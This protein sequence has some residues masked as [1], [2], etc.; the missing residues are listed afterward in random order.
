MPGVFDPADDALAAVQAQRAHRDSYLAAA[1]A[2][3]AQLAGANRA[4]YPFLAAGDTLALAKSGN[5]PDSSVTRTVAD[6][7]VKHKVKRGFGFRSIGDWISGSAALGKGIVRGGMT[8]LSAP[9]TEAA[10]VFRNITASAGTTAGGATGGAAI[11]A[12]LGTVVPGVGN[13]VGAGVGALAGGTIGAIGGFLARKKVKV[14]D[15][16]W[17]PQSEALLAA[18]HILQGQKVDLGTGYFP[19]GELAEEHAVRSRNVTVDGHGLTPGRLIAASVAEPGSQ[20]HRML[21]GLI[22]FGGALKAD[23]SA[24]VLGEVGKAKVA[25]RMFNPEDAGLIAGL[26]KTVATDRVD[27]WLS[28]PKGKAVIDQLAADSSFDSIWR[29]TNK[30]LDVEDALALSKIDDPAEVAAYLRPK[31]G[32]DIREKPTLSDMPWTNPT[33]R[34]MRDARIWQDVPGRAI[35]FDDPNGAV[36]QVDRFLRNANIRDPEIIARH[37]TAMAEA[38]VAGNAGDR[39]Q[40]VKAVGDVVREAVKEGLRGKDGTLSDPAA[41]KARALTDLF[42]NRHEELV[43]FNVDDIGDNAWHPGVKV[44]ADTKPAAS[45]HL[46]VEGLNSKVLLPDYRDIRRAT[47]KYGQVL[48]NPLIKTPALFLDHVMNTLWKPLVLIR[49]AW[50]VRVVGEEQIRMAAA[51][52][53]SFLNHPLSALAT[54]VSDDGRLGKMLSKVGVDTGRGETDVLGELF[55]DARKLAPEP[56]ALEGALYKGRVADPVGKART[57]VTRHKVLYDQMAPEYAK[58]WAEELMQL[59]ADPIGVR[60]AAGGLLEGDRTVNRLPGIDGLKDWFWHGTGQQ[61]RRDLIDQGVDA[62]GREGADR[63]IDSV[64]ERLRT[65]TAGNG[66]LAQAV[67]TGQWAD[68]PLRA[69]DKINPDFVRKLDEIRDLGPTRVKG[70]LNVYA[71]DARGEFGRRAEHAVNWMFEQL[72]VKPSNA[73]SRSPTFR[74]A[75]WDR[76]TELTPF[77]DE[78]TQTAAIKA[79]AE[80]GLKR[81]DLRKIAKAALS[82]KGEVADLSVADDLAK[83]HALETTRHLLYDLADKGQASDQLRLVFPFAE[84]WKEVV[85]RWSGLLV[86]NPAIARRSEQGVLGARGAG[87]FQPDPTTGEETFTYPGS[88]FLS[89][90]LLG[91]PVPL[92]GRVQGLSLA[93]SVIPGFGPVVQIPASKIIPNRPDWDWLREAV[94]PFGEPDT[95]GG[96]VESF[97]PAW[98][99]KFRTAFLR[100]DPEHD[101]MFANTMMDVARY[102]MTTG[103]Y[104]TDT[105]DDVQRLLSAASSKAKGVYVLRGAAQFFAPSAPTPQ[106]LAKDPDGHYV[107]AQKLIEDYQA[108]QQADPDNAVSTFLGKYG[109]GALLFMQPKTQGG[110]PATTDLND[111]VR[112]HPE[113][114]SKFKDVYAFFGPQTGEFSFD[115][116]NRQLRSGERKPVTPAEAVKGANQRVASMIYRQARDKIVGNTTWEAR[117]WLGQVRD[118]LIDQYPGYDPLAYDDSRIPK[119]IRSLSRAV[120]DPELA[121]TDAGHAIGL[122][123]GAREK[124]L[125]AAKESRLQSFAT[126]KAAEPLRDWLRS[127]GEA[128]V[129]QTADFAPVWDSVL[130]REMI[131]DAPDTTQRAVA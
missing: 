95:E 109:E 89:E 37:T 38:T 16:D 55:R 45:P 1:T 44:G 112:D 52:Y 49:G 104:S 42:T 127:I 22:D 65:K 124:A 51:G 103:D 101:R 48:D 58:S 26:R 43:R 3:T 59:R 35:N 106:F 111:W 20:P 30:K 7:R 24:L 107:V 28:G 9:Y 116:Y 53:D 57:V 12:G 96:F 79:A 56:T 91:M 41:R 62:V 114:V 85:T 113:Q 73:L 46:L 18:G 78:A 119:L 10:G 77:M 88:Q 117:S 128:L 50:P 32:V 92:T 14:G 54:V 99:Q 74:Q 47:T 4:A 87:W 34:R 63:Y 60:A 70:D 98:M 102:L 33:V 130:S 108:M 76:I 64:V 23:P 83:A 100:N 97:L 126:A 61:I 25:A 131:E 82:G 71:P 90:H 39:Y 80:A 29:R 125:A 121:R 15:A 72:M 21:S 84:A 13:L 2:Q 69:G 40:T 115:L 11:G 6:A 17:R 94:V 8:V 66:D 122:Y 118:A 19:G 81:D 67:A 31:L 129:S 93:A 68:V 75:Y 5:G 120:D 123:L 86:D 110:G 105:P 27:G 36:E